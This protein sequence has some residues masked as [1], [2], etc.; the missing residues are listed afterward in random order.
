MFSSLVSWIDLILH[1]VVVL[2]ILQGLTSFRK[3]SDLVSDFI[4][5]LSSS[6]V[7]HAVYSVTV[8]NVS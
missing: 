4:Q 8:L 5:G 6:D 3:V 1:I 7:E 2:T